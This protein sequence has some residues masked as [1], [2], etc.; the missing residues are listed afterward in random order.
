MISRRVGQVSCE[1]RSSTDV[2]LGTDR[3]L[4]RYPV[5]GDLPKSNR[6]F[7]T[8]VLPR[9]FLII[10]FSVETVWGEK[11]ISARL[12]FLG[13]IFSSGSLCSSPLTSPPHS[14]HSLGSPKFV[15]I[16][17]V[18][19]TRGYF[20]SRPAAEWKGWCRSRQSISAQKGSNVPSSKGVAVDTTPELLH[21]L[22]G[23]A[24]LSWDS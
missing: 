18:P 8:S 7:C 3:C 23:C 5:L 16:R 10:A 21:T 11:L 1:R 14:S 20:P 6:N 17:C 13:K 4:W 9:Q 15:S 12:S 22:P 19:S 2:V 24:D